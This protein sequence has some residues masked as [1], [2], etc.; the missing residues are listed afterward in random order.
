MAFGS[1]D[2]SEWLLGRTAEQQRVASFPDSVFYYDCKIDAALR[3]R[4]VSLAHAYADSLIALFTAERITSIQ[5]QAWSPDI[6]MSLA[7]SYAR[8]GR[9]SDA[10]ILTRSV[11]GN[12]A[13]PPKRD[14]AALVITASRV[15]T[16]F[17]QTGDTASAI[18]W[19][20]RG[21]Q[22]GSTIGGYK[23]DPR[24]RPLHGTAVFE[25]FVREYDR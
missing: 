16:V 4:G 9:K 20:R 5:R 10:T 7:Y 8:V 2:L 23:M 22:E 3:S 17:A 21:L 1:R 12:S 14:T 15:A 25:R 19:L 11:I 18:R 6:M 13:K 24:L